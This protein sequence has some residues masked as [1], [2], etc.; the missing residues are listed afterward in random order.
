MVEGAVGAAFMAAGLPAPRGAVGADGLSS[1]E[2][3]DVVAS[4]QPDVRD[5]TLSRPLALPDLIDVLQEIWLEENDG[6]GKTHEDTSD[7][8]W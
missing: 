4:L 7:E 8:G 1:S 3:E 5:F 2:F 6:Y